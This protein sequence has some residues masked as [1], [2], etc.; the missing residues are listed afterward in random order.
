MNTLQTQRPPPSQTCS[1]AP[2]LTTQ[3]HDSRRCRLI[4]ATSLTLANCALQ[5]ESP[6]LTRLQQVAPR[7]LMLHLRLTDESE[8][9][10]L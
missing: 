4:G 10:R 8:M 1:D 6:Q 7:G 5:E 3:W 2:S 9:Y